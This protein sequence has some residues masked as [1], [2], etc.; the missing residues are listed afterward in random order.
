MTSDSPSRDMFLLPKPDVTD[1]V[2]HLGIS[3]KPSTG[4]TINLRESPYYP[5]LKLFA[6]KIDA[7][8][9]AQELSAPWVPVAFACGYLVTNGWHFQDANGLLKTFCPVPHNVIEVLQD[10]VRELQKSKYKPK[11]YPAYITNALADIPF[12]KTIPR[13]SY[14]AVCFCT[15]MRLGYPAPKDQP[16]DWLTVPAWALRLNRRRKRLFEG[17]LSLE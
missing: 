13:A 4:N 16:D 14:E 1:D 6:A 12:M 2:T 17:G 5:S 8:R 11:D 9:R 10:L 7:Q 3:D 15:V